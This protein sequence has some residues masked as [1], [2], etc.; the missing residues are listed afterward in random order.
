MNS[1]RMDNRTQGGLKISQQLTEPIFGSDSIVLINLGRKLSTKWRSFVTAG[2][3]RNLGMPQMF[4]Q[5]GEMSAE[6]EFNSYGSGSA[7][8]KNVGG[9]VGL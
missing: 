2:R 8:L 7:G 6:K 4:W 3:S 5:V 1:F 9:L